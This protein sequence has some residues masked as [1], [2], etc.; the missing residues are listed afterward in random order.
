[1]IKFALNLGF[2]LLLVFVIGF[3]T[4]DFLTE[5]RGSFFKS[6]V[7]V[8]GVYGHGSGVIID[9]NSEYSLV[10]TNE[11]VCVGTSV[12]PKDYEDLYSLMFL[13]SLLKMMGESDEAISDISN[14][15]SRVIAK[16]DKQIKNAKLEVMMNLSKEKKIGTIH[17]YSDTYDL[18]V[19]KVP[20]TNKPTILLAADEPT[21]GD[22]VI[23]HGNPLFMENHV[24]NGNVGESIVIEGNR[25]T[26]HSAII[27][28]GN[29][30]SGSFNSSSMLIGINTL[31]VR[32]MPTGTYVVPLSDIKQFL[33][34]RNIKHR[35]FRKS[36][37]RRIYE[38]IKNNI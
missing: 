22:F 11:H 37:I 3:F 29:S 26:Q 2:R 6:G 34:M 18:C 20:L 12:N 35:T 30:G 10:L 24:T 27:Y 21:I 19:V 23:T 31:G 4:I 17:A 33:N 9:S 28:G 15:I 38:H 25:Y 32:N 36:L 8:T 14:Q 16:I 7:K 13:E 5:E 1:M